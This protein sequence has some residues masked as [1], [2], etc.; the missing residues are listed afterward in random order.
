MT[1][2]PRTWSTGRRPLAAALAL[3]GAWLTLR[4]LNRATRRVSGSSMEPTLSD[5]DLVLTLPSAIRSPREGDVVTIHDP[6]DPDRVAVKRIVATEGGW[7]SLPGGPGQ[8]P[9]DHVAVRGDQPWSSTDSRTYGPVPSD[10]IDRY[11][12][13]RLWPPRLVL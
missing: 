7:A 6:R 13:A 4:A 5:G 10:L 12:V 1:G 9:H 11:V 2:T 8:I 3:G